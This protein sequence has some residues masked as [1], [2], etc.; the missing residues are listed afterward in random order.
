MIIVLELLR[1]A[2][3]RLPKPIAATL[4]IVGGLVIGREVVS[5]NLVSTTMIVVIAL[6]AVASFSIPSNEMRIALRL[7]SI[8][9]MFTSALFG[10]AGL[11]FSF[12]LLLMHLTKLETYGVPY[13]YPLSPLNPVQLLP[14]LI[15]LPRR[16][17]GRKTSK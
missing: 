11:A 10:L 17:F 5:A 8:P 13:F 2:A 16:L 6:N 12:S 3:I 7:I 1:E 14:A 4:S 15:Q 9:I